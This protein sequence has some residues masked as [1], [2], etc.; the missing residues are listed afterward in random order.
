MSLSSVLYAAYLSSHACLIK[1]CTPPCTWLCTQ[2]PLPF[3]AFIFVNSAVLDAPFFIAVFRWDPKLALLWLLRL[4]LLTTLLFNRWGIQ[5]LL[6]NKSL[7]QFRWT[8]W[9]YWIRQWERSW[10]VYCTIHH[11]LPEFIIRWNFPKL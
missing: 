1:I 3:V 11:K 7:W 8:C 6:P 5:T 4:S 9:T 2:V 10:S